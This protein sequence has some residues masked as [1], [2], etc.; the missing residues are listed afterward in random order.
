M[1]A[2]PHWRRTRNVTYVVDVLSRHSCTDCGEDQPLVLEFDHVGK[3]RASVTTLAWREYSLETVIA[4]ISKC[5]IRCANCHRR[6]TA[7]ERRH[8]RHD[9]SWP[10]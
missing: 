10:L 4:E 2:E 1:D 3:K 8:F 7:R 6:R 5:E 9:A